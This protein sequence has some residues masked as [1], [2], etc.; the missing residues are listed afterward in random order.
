MVESKNPIKNIEEEEIID[1]DRYNKVKKR[2]EKRKKC[3]SK[4]Q[5]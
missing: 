4:Q 2:N 3:Q 1:I 5:V